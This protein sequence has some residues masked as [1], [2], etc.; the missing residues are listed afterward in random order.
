MGCIFWH[1]RD[2]GDQSVSKYVD[3]SSYKDS[4]ANDCKAIR[5]LR[6]AAFAL[7]HGRLIR[8]P[9]QRVMTEASQMTLGMNS[10]GFFQA[11]DSVGSSLVFL[12]LHTGSIDART[13]IGKAGNFL[14][15]VVATV[16]P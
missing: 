4:L 10:V 6:D 13:V 1:L 5:E 3:D 14:K 8:K 11:G 2:K 9:E 16:D 15:G 12:D 7:K